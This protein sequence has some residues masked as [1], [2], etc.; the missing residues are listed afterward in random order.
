M[1]TLKLSVSV[2][3]KLV[4][5]LYMKTNKQIILLKITGE[6]LLGQGKKEL[7]STQIKNIALQ[8]KKLQ[9]T[10]QFGI[11]IGGGN[12]FRGTKEGKQLGISPSVGHQIGMLGTMM[13][14]L[15]LKDIFEQ[16]DI[17]CSLFCAVPAAEVGIPI[18]Q[19]A[20]ESALAKERCPIFTGGTGNPFFTTDTTAVLRGLQINAREVWKGTR[21]EGIYDKD[22]QQFPDAHLIRQI[23]YQKALAQE[24]AILDSTAF[25]LAQR[26]QLPLRVFN[27]FAPD[28]LLQAAHDPYFG[29]IVR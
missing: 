28:A 24:L 16:H 9:E 2:V 3:L 4:A 12:F 6:A 22:P 15:I 18:S 10:H 14:G 1:K 17:L 23:S 7:D 19:Q 11:V 5:D 21:V 20:I 13:N 25:A 8:I 29:S 26:H 27:I